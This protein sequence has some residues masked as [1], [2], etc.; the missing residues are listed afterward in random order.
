MGVRKDEA[1]ELMVKA[2]KRFEKDK[3]AAKDLRLEKVI[4]VAYDNELFDSFL[5]WTK[6]L[7]QGTR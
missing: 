4:L 2:I 5:K 6:E 7:R 3:E 1:A